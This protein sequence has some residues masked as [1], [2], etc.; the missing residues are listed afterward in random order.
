MVQTRR[1]ALSVLLV[2]V[3]LRGFLL[4]DVQ[5]KIDAA[6]KP[7]ELVEEVE[8]VIEVETVVPNPDNGLP[9]SAAWDAGMTAF[10]DDATT[11]DNP[12]T[13]QDADDWIGGF[14][15]A[16]DRANEEQGT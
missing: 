16:Y 9:G 15:F 12:H 14:S 13:G 8:E 11:D 6:N 10:K 7:E 2:M 4:A 1:V 3:G 5:E